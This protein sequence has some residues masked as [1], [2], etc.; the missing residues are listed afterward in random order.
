MLEYGV[1][2]LYGSILQSLGYSYD[3]IQK[4]NKEY[5][6]NKLPDHYGKLLLT[7]GY[8]LVGLHYY[9]EHNK[10]TH[11][12]HDIGY[13]MILL[14]YVLSY[15]NKYN[16]PHKNY[17]LLAIIAFSM[18][19]LNTQ[20]HNKNVILLG[21]ITAIAFYILYVKDEYEEINEH[22]EYK[23]Q[24]KN[25]EDHE[26]SINYGTLLHTIGGTIFIG[27]YLHKYL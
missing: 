8:I 6:K 2:G 27:H 19:V 13:S 12:Y 7:L 15:L 21:H 11:L 24:Y 25:I 16:T 14:F 26:N 18:I 3:V 5:N 4:Y 1:L 20:L 22:D 9:D 23:E 10:Y 17:E